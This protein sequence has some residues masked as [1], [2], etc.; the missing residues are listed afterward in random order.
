MPNV[1]INAQTYDVAAGTR[2]VNAI[3]DNGVSIGHRCGGKARCASCRVVFVAG[4][5][6]QITT[7][8]HEK[9][10]DKGLYGEARLSCQILVDRDMT[11]I[12]QMTLESMPDWSDTGPRCIDAI[13]PEPAF[14]EK[15]SL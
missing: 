9:L 3:E 6:Q 12:P 2:L 7:A 8:E 10:V 11:V 13:E 14:V 1:T 4:E 5:P 15:T